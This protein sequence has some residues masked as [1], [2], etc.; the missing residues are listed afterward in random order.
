MTAQFRFLESALLLIGVMILTACPPRT[1]PAK[2]ETF[3]GGF[4]ERFD[5]SPRIAIAYNP[6]GGADRAM[7]SHDGTPIGAMFVTAPPP[8]GTP[9]DVM[10]DVIIESTKAQYGATAVKY[11]QFTNQAGYTFHHYSSDAH[12]DGASYRYE[13][14]LHIDRR[15]MPSLAKSM[16]VEQFGMHKFEFIIPD[17]RFATV[18]PLLLSVVDSFT[19][20]EE[21]SKK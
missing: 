18:M 21:Q 17:K 8:V 3:V 6:H 20:M 13:L 14:F 11:S 1:S 2:R 4:G 19:P 12:R 16:L 15:K 7:F 5:Y 9:E 10:K